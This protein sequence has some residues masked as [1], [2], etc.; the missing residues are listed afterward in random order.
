MS[1]LRHCWRA[2]MLCFA[3]RLASAP[4]PASAPPRCRLPLSWRIRRS[5]RHN[6]IHTIPTLM[7][8]L[9]LLLH[10]LLLRL[11]GCGKIRVGRVRMRRAIRHRPV[12][13]S[14]LSSRVEIHAVLVSISTSKAASEVDC[15][16]SETSMLQAEA[17]AIRVD[18]PRL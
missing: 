7:M 14:A 17:D 11:R 12:P 15:E 1:L 18:C 8:L 2:C 4:C 13:L 5:R 9:L 16:A 6:S 10:M 3:S